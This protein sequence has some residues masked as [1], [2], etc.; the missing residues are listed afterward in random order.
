MKMTQERRDETANYHLLS[1]NKRWWDAP[2]ARFS[3][4]MTAVLEAGKA[5]TRGLVELDDFKSEVETGV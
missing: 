4:G 3:E 1:S 5:G 2:E